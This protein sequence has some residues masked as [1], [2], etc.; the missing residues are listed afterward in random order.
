MR[1]RFPTRYPRS[2]RAIVLIF[3]AL[4][5]AGLSGCRKQAASSSPEATEAGLRALMEKFLK[6][7]A[8]AE[9]LMARLRPTA[10]DFAAVF[11]SDVVIAA[12]S[13][14][15]RI[16]ASQRYQI[17]PRP[18]QTQLDLIGASTEEHR[19]GRSRRMSR[20]Y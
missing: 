7:E 5:A 20:G 14:Y 9:A 11:K 8:D 19:A 3:A 4:L 6:P 1:T 17:A 10:A 2:S 12:K 13:H 15:D 18:E 16:Y